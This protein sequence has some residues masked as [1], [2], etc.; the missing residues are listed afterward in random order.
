MDFEKIK[1]YLLNLKKEDFE[2]GKLK[3]AHTIQDVEYFKLDNDLEDFEV[4]NY[5]EY[6]LVDILGNDLT[7]VKNTKKRYKTPNGRVVNAKIIKT[8]IEDCRKVYG[9]PLNGYWIVPLQ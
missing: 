2:N 4:I 8:I 3:K 6:F 1:E 5:G 9:T 7:I